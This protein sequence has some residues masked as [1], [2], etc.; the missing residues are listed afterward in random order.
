MVIGFGPSMSATITALSI[1]SASSS[2]RSIF[3]QCPHVSLEL[4]N[5]TPEV[6]P[7]AACVML[8]RRIRERDHLGG[9]GK[10]RRHTSAEAMYDCAWSARI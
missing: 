5:H 8:E 2:T 3:A 4:T 1:S 9:V 6:C 10:T 7:V